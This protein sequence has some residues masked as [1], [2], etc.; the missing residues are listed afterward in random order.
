MIRRF[1]QCK[2]TK[3]RLDLMA[4]SNEQEWAEGELDTVMEIFGLKV[5]AGA[6]KNEKWAL[7]MLSLTNKEAADAEALGQKVFQDVE[8]VKTHSEEELE[9]LSDLSAYLKVCG[10]NEVLR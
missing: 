9:H 7:I 10:E 8:E 3:E 1:I 2:N 5:P 4:A 6:S